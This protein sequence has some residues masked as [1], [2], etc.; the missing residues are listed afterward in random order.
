MAN[1]IDLSD[2]KN[3]WW[4][5]VYVNPIH[6]LIQTWSIIFY[7]QNPGCTIYNNKLYVAGGIGAGG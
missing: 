5:L 6:E 7:R 2:N 1:V 4:C 3:D